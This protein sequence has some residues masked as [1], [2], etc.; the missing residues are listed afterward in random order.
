MA[1]QPEKKRLKVVLRLCIE[2]AKLVPSRS[3]SVVRTGGVEE[4]RLC[5]GLTIDLG[6]HL[7]SLPSLDAFVRLL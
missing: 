3:E 6:L 7:S 4:K 5:F 2:G 1:V